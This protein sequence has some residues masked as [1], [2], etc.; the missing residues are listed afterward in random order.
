M[1]TIR[2]PLTLVLLAFV[3][4]AAAARMRPTS[5]PITTEWP[6]LVEK[7]LHALKVF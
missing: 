3:A 2:F 7:W 6:K 4:R 1:Q 5:D